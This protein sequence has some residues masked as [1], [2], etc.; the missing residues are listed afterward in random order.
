[1]E[2]MRAALLPLLPAHW[3]LR[4]QLGGWRPIDRAWSDNGYVYVKLPSINVA[5]MPN[6]LVTVRPQPPHPE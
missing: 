4:D 6:D 3:E 1:M 2:T 5:Y